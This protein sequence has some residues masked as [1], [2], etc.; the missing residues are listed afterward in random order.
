M[1]GDLPMALLLSRAD[2]FVEAVNRSW[3]GLAGLSIEQSLGAGWL[4]RIDPRDQGPLLSGIR[5]TAAQ[6]H[7]VTTRL[8]WAAAAAQCE[9][10]VTVDGQPVRC[11]LSRHEESDVLIALM[12]D[13]VPDADPWS[14][15]GLLDLVTY[16]LFDLTL[17]LAVCANFSQ[18]PARSRIAAAIE[19]IDRVIGSIRDTTTLDLPGGVL[20]L[21]G[22]PRTSP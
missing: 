11:R 17:D 1:T 14:G 5:N 8:D 16:D 13:L 2:G 22:G 19:R 7:G 10:T 4:D 15:H 3:C 12:R 9:I 6:H 21:R 18:E 20:D